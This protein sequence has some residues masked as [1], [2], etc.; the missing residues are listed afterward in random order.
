MRWGS[1]F[2]LSPSAD[3]I[4]RSQFKSIMKALLVPL[5]LIAII[6][7]MLLPL[8]AMLLDFLIVANVLLGFVLLVSAVYIGEPMRLSALPTVLLFATLYRLALNISTTRLILG[9]GE[10][11]SVVEAFGSVVIQ[12]NLIVGLTV[13]LV[14]TIVQ[15]IVIAKGAERVAEVAARFTLDAL[16]GKQM[17]ID[18]DVRAGLLDVEGARRK[19]QE[20]QIES[21]FYGAL[22]GSMKFIKGDAIAG[23]IIVAINLVGGFLLGVTTQRL[24]LSEALAQYSLLTVGDGLASQLP[25]LLNALAAGIVVTRVTRGDGKSLASEVPAQLGQLKVVKVMV[26]VL[27]LALGALPGMPL[28]PFLGL[29]LLALI[30]AVTHKDVPD[31]Q[32]IV[33]PAFKPRPSPL[34]TL[35]FGIQTL[36]ALRTHAKELETRLDIWRQDVFD[37]FGMVLPALD[38]RADKVGSYTFRILLRGIEVRRQQDSVVAGKLIDELLVELN[39]VIEWHSIELIDDSMTRRMLDALEKQHPEL[40]AAVVPNV[41]STTQL[42]VLLRSLVK[43]GINV[44]N[45]DV[46]LQAVAENSGRAA[47]ERVLLEEARVALG[48]QV[49]MLLVGEGG[50]LPAH[51]VEPMIDIALAETERSGKTLDPNLIGEFLSVIPEQIS[52]DKPL[53]CS[54]AARALLRDCLEVR[55][56]RYQVIAYEELPRGVHFVN[57]GTVG[58]TIKER[59]HE[60]FVQKLA[61]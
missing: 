29:G 20:L 57:A 2:L 15:F 18:A 51:S 26:A 53:I 31:E 14:V 47:S 58:T 27:A 36:E 48:R 28:L 35:E 1:G 8:P 24:G 50:L 45:L 21:R 34:L 7:S 44:R 30:L 56:L 40:V 3:W 52:K 22:D 16:P 59:Y 9:S 25:A 55:G 10:G 5:A 32:E 37:K 12:G 6:G 49:T 33:L 60:D 39:Q 11:G 4:I 17:S 54:K 38:I 61:A 13:F 43:E 19:R 23:L 41:V 42:T 46:I